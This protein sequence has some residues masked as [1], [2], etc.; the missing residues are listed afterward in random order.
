MT[1]TKLKA[2]F[3]LVALLT[4][5]FVY[6]SGLFLLGKYTDWKLTSNAQGQKVSGQNGVQKPQPEN[7]TQSAS[8]LGSTVKLCSNTTYSFQLAYPQDWFTTYNTKDQACNYFAPYSFVLPQIPSENITP[9][10]IQR[11]DPEN[12]DI[13]VKSAQNPNDL[14]NIEKTQNIEING[15][16]V[17]YVEAASTGSS[18]QRGFVKASFFVFDANNPLEI[19]YTQ[20]DEKENVIETKKVLND[21]ANSLKFF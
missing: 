5:F 13:A 15:K 12:W 19:T 16:P 10:T 18:I 7:E 1:L 3:K 2:N 14:Y 9:I 11:M 20:L 8:V 4:A 6:S 21:I 17:Q